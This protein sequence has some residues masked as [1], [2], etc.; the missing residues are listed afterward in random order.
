MNMMIIIHL[1]H[2]FHSTDCWALSSTHMMLGLIAQ[3]LGCWTSKS[4][5]WIMIWQTSTSSSSLRSSFCCYSIIRWLK[6]ALAST[7][8]PRVS[9]R[10][11]NIKYITQVKTRPPVFA[12]FCN[13]E[14]IPGAYERF[15]RWA[16]L[17][18]L[19]CPSASLRS[20]SWWCYWYFRSKLQKD[21]KL[22]GVPVRFV[23]RK[24]ENEAF[25]KARS[26]V[27]RVATGGRSAVREVRFPVQVQQKLKEK[28][29]NA[30]PPSKRKVAG[31]KKRKALAL[32]EKSNRRRSTKKKK[33]S[34]TSPSPSPSSSTTQRRRQRSWSWLRGM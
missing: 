7:K 31:I 10:T 15:L 12:L 19:F 28:R 32:E 23:I 24:T 16:L 14:T 17:S 27:K 25:E 29:K 6:D 34:A 2:Y 21:F 3:A 26:A 5:A 33:T 4:T 8:S 11:V 22:Q 30:T 9:G 1:R 20:T 18:L 13:M